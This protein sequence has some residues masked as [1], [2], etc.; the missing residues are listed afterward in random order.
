[1][2]QKNIRKTDLL[3]FKKNIR[4]RDSLS[5][6]FALDGQPFNSGE[7]DA[8]LAGNLLKGI[9]SLVQSSD[10]ELSGKTTVSL[11]IKATKQ[12]S[13]EFWM[14]LCELINNI[15]SQTSIQ[16]TDL[17]VATA[18]ASSLGFVENAFGVIDLILKL[19]G[20]EAKVIKQTKAEVIVKGNNNGNIHVHK[21][22][23]NL[24]TNSDVRTALSEIFTPLVSD[25]K[26]TKVE[27]RDPES[28]KVI[29]RI[30]SDEMKYFYYEP[31]EEYVQ[32]SVITTGVRVVK[33]VYEGD[34]QWRV[35]YEGQSVDAKII[36]KD[37]LKKFQTG[38]VE[39]PP[40]STL[41]VVLIKKTPIMNDKVIGK[42]RFEIAKINN[43]NLP[44]K[45]QKLL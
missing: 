2:V 19:K 35:K 32:E 20:K 39:A 17:K 37:W 22:V 18:I 41:Q 6:V 34:A 38:L 29:K 8:E 21:N 44:P 33:A 28:K 16:G 24:Y 11:K 13:F 23:I 1:M 31:K 3:S 25:Q 9:S 45:Q 42:P 15:S 26:N 10:A 36:D 27:I 14:N 43:V 40:R 5:F 30:N 7:M 4:E 12:G